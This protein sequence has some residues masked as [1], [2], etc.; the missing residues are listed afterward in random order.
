MG[1][2]L[3]RVWDNIA[4]AIENKLDPPSKAENYIFSELSAGIMA[5][6]KASNKSPL[7][8]LQMGNLTMPYPMIDISQGD[9]GSRLQIDLALDGTQHVTGSLEGMGSYKMQFMDC[10]A[11]LSEGG[12][13]D[14]MFGITGGRLLT[15]LASDDWGLQPTMAGQYLAASNIQHRSV[16]VRV[17]NRNNSSVNNNRWKGLSDLPTIVGVFRGIATNIQIEL[18]PKVEGIVNVF[19]KTQLDAIGS[20]R[21]T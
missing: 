10:P 19:I 1:R 12:Y 17:Y 3:G 18:Q 9:Q 15:G 11:I 5:G 7:A 8:V 21:T 20:W 13:I 16:T 4:S 2:I 6:A 14:K